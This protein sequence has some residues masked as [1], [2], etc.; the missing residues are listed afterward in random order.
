[1]MIADFP[2]LWCIVCISTNTVEYTN[3]RYTAAKGFLDGIPESIRSQ[4]Y[5][6]RYDPNPNYNPLP[7]E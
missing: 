6:V 7:N 5:L 4:F 1:M 3:T 2:R